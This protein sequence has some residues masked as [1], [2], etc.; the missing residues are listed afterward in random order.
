M[1]TPPLVL[2][3]S[4]IGLVSH[5]LSEG[6]RQLLTKRRPFLGCESCALPPP[7]PPLFLDLRVGLD[8]PLRE[9]KRIIPGLSFCDMVGFSECHNDPD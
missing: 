9:M 7:P 5:F 4:P 3:P 8:V 6:G 1:T 2:S